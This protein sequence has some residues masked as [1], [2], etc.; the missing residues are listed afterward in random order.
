MQVFSLFEGGQRRQTLAVMDCQIELIS[1]I[2]LQPGKIDDDSPWFALHVL[3]G[4][5]VA[6]AGVQLVQ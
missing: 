2:K 1:S 6:V 4:H 3:D 5:S